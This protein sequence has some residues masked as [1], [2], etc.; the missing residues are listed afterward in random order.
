M[1]AVA[2]CCLVAAMVG[3]PTASAASHTTAHAAVSKK[4]LAKSLKSTRKI[5]TRNRAAIKKL[6]TALAKGITDLRAAITGGDKTVDDKINSIVAITTPILQQLGAGLTQAGAGLVALQ[7]AALK[8]KAGLEEL[9]AGTKL[10]GDFVKADEYGAVRAFQRPAASTDEADFDAIPGISA[11]SAN[12]PDN[13]QGA[14]VS[15]SVPFL[16]TSGGPVDVTLRAAIRSNESDGAATGPPAGQVGGIFY[17]K[18][19]A[20]PGQAPTSC[21]GGVEPGAIVCAPSGPPP[22]QDFGPLVGVQPLENIQTKDPATSFAAPTAED[23]VNPT[24]EVANADCTIPG[25]GLY[26]LTFAVQFFDFP[27]STTPGPTE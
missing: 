7:D 27:T 6:N 21:P 20:I 5:A 19:A 4:A 16:N 23:D 15:A 2:A 3:A 24:G 18:C 12:I 22:A 11:N 13:G 17:A 1:L 9:A 10:L 8:L 26:E 14:L 25:N